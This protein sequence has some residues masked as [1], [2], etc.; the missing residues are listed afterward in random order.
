MGRVKPSYGIGEVVERTGVAEATLRMWERRYGF[1]APERLASGHRRFSERDVEL[2]RSVAAKRASGLALPV[3]IEQA[4]SLESQ[5]TLSVYAALRRRRPD[6]EPRTLLKPMMLALTRAIEDE[7]LARAERSIVFGS[8]QRERFYRQSQ[9]RWR[10]LARTA[11]VAVVLADFTRLRTRRGEPTEVPVP[12]EHPLNREWAL[13]CEGEDFALCLTGW[14]PPESARLP[15]WQR[16]FE[17]IW[18]VEPDAVRE[19]SLICAGIAEAQRPALIAAA[20]A[21]LQTPL[22]LSL[23]AQLRLSTA[24]SA[25]MLAHLSSRLGAQRKAPPG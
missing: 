1:P 22:A 13:V 9:N 25:R 6:L 11:D 20:Q 24:V 19:A 15:D 8:F 16:R 17:A 21:R 5:P 14:E 18:S 4:R 7:T 10:E 12:R 2:I 3:A 23:G